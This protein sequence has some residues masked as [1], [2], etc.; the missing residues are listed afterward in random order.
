MSYIYR[1]NFDIDSAEFGALSIGHELQRS[2]GY[3]RAILPNEPGY[4]TSRAMYSLSNEEKT[5]IVFESVWD[6]WDDIELHRSQS[7]LN[8]EKLLHEFKL[9]VQL[10]N[11]ESHIFEEIA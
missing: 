11:L 7:M 4:I 5:H 10:L 9:K 1:I 6:T 3:L 8:E 2:V